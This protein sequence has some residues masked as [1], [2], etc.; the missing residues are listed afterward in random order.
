MEALLFFSKALP[1]PCG[2]C[3]G[4]LCAE[5]ARSG[6][7]RQGL[8]A[9]HFRP[10]GTCGGGHRLDLPA[11]VAAVIEAEAIAKGDEAAQA[12]VQVIRAVGPELV[13]EWLRD[14][15]PHGRRLIREYAI[16]ATESDEEWAAEN[17]WHGH[18]TN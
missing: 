8:T 1:D 16:S 14:T 9:V 4:L 17:Y 5:C 11:A 2:C 18:G 3:Q 6:P 10:D 7:G 15:G 13:T 12:A